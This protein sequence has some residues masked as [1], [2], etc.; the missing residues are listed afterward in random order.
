MKREAD[1]D[2]LD[3]RP[4]TDETRAQGRRQVLQSAQQG[5]GQDKHDDRSGDAA[6]LDEAG[7]LAEIDLILGTGGTRRG[8]EHTGTQ[9]RRAQNGCNTAGHAMLP[10]WRRTRLRVRARY[11]SQDT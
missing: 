2:H 3:R 10:R 6:P 11:Q 4:P 5:E 1:F 7:Q 8:Q 9:G